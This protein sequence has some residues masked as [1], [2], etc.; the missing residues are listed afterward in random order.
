MVTAYGP[1]SG[2]TVEIRNQIQASIL[3]SSRYTHEY[4]PEYHNHD[5]T[6]FRPIDHQLPQC[7]IDYFALHSLCTAKALVTMR[8]LG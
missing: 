3:P 4:V 5:C 1:A 8:S 6:T 2:A 7:P